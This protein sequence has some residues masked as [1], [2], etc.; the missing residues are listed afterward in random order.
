M[1]IAAPLPASPLGP[2][3]AQT[4]PPPNGAFNLY[5]DGT[6]GDDV[7]GDGISSNGCLTVRKTTHITST[8]GHFR[9]ACLTAD[10]PP[11]SL[12]TDLPRDRTLDGQPDGRFQRASVGRPRYFELGAARVGSPRPRPHRARGW[13]SRE[14]CESHRNLACP[15]P[16]CRVRR[17]A[18][19]DM[20]QHRETLARP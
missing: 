3:R 5:D 15:V 9:R 6:H 1:E 16:I 7:A 13:S 11:H 12:A 8:P 19:A 17:P 2:A 10:A 14:Q 18:N 4:S 20:A